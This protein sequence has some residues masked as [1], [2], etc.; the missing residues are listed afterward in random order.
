MSHDIF[1]IIDFYLLTRN[2]WMLM[3]MIVGSLKFPV[4]LLVKSHGFPARS[5]LKTI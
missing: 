1:A 4:R 2:R 3:I 5:H